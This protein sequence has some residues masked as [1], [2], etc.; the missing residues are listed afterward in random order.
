MATAMDLRERAHVLEVQRG[1][2]LAE[3]RRRVRHSPPSAAATPHPRPTG[4]DPLRAQL[5][6]EI[7]SRAHSQELPSPAVGAAPP[8]EAQ[9]EALFAELQRRVRR[10][11]E[12]P[13]HEE[14]REALFDE[15]H[16]RVSRTP[17]SSQRRASA[18]PA[19]PPRRSP[20]APSSTPGAPASTPR[21]TPAS[22]PRRTPAA[23]PPP[24]LSAA[25]GS[26][27]RTPPS[28]GGCSVLS[29]LSKEQLTSLG[30][31][32]RERASSSAALKRALADDL[33]MAAG[34]AAPAAPGS[35]LFARD[36][37]AVSAI[38]LRALAR[39]MRTARAAP[40]SPVSAVAR[41]E[42]DVLQPLS[43]ERVRRVERALDAQR[44]GALAAEQRRQLLA[45]T[46]LGV[47]WLG[48][49][50]LLD[51]CDLRARAE[52]TAHVVAC[53][54]RPLTQRAQCE[55]RT[56]LLGVRAL[57]LPVLGPATDFHSY[58]WL[59]PFRETLRAA[60]GALGRKADQ[61]SRFLWWDLFCQNQWA[62][63][64]V[65]GAF[66]G[67]IAQAERLLLSVPNPAR[68]LAIGRTWVLFEVM[69]AVVSGTPV[70]VIVNPLAPGALRADVDAL[71]VRRAMATRPEDRVRI[72][73][74][75]EARVPGGAPALN[76]TVRRVVV[77]GLAAV[78]LRRRAAHGLGL[79]RDSS[80]KWTHPLVARV[81]CAALRGGVGGS[82]RV[83]LDALAVPAASGPSV[84]GVPL[85]EVPLA[86][87]SPFLADAP[88][89][90]ADARGRAVLCG[91]GGCSLADKALAAQGAGAVALLIGNTPDTPLVSRLLPAQDEAD[92]PHTLQI[93]VV[94]VDAETSAALA[95]AC[96]QQQQQR[97]LLE[98]LSQRQRSGGG[99]ARR[100]RT[101]ERAERADASPGALPPRGRPIA[102]GAGRPGA[103]VVVSIVYE[104]ADLGSH[105]V[106]AQ[107]IKA[108]QAL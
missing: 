86:V 21:R 78:A 46:E 12:S 30:A 66:R 74:L 3:L 87:A 72:L 32:L 64:D 79:S 61:R 31:D 6:A 80:G 53:V 98:Q 75:V 47:C 43:E 5:V 108:V 92:G 20:G 50:L 88:L 48:V 96:W 99:G 89:R 73:Q 9:R 18:P 15:L 106:D 97:E 29:R 57:G 69:Q 63:G 14:Q 54:V 16:R 1:A 60:R 102:S 103:S 24:P 85:P 25:R 13:A 35:P 91:R 26:A 83:L 11:P 76:S 27:G 107:L 8:S 94:M 17:E 44:N 34:T 90:Q 105:G 40:P 36:I 22:T 42:D 37:R 4:R 93:P 100:S 67:A 70:E 58:T 51:L 45:G 56:L 55:L 2:L 62:P 10:A 41:A 19:S 95:R 71:D 49:E 77:R 23:R 65:E 104:H 82:D 38:E 28:A 68:P 59:E 101:P 7:V 84:R 39:Y 33:A 52:P 81:R